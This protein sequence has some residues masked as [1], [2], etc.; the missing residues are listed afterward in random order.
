MIRPS[1]KQR[2]ALQYL[3]HCPETEQ[4]LYGGAAFGGKSFLGCFWQLSRRCMFPETRGVIGRSELKNLKLTTLQTFWKVWDIH[5]KGIFTDIHLN[6]NEQKSVI[7]FSNGSEIYLKDI[8]YYPSDPDFHSLGSLE[9]TDSFVDEGGESV[10]KAINIIFSRTRHNLIN[11][12]PAM[13]IASNPANNWLKHNF[14]MDS[15]GVPIQLPPYRKYIQ[16][17]ATDN[18]DKDAVTRYIKTLERLPLYDRMRLLEG[19]WSVNENDKPFFHMFNSDNHIGENAVIKSEPLYLSF[20]FNIKPT[21]CVIGQKIAGVGLIVHDCVQVEGGTQRLCEQ[22]QHLNTHRA[23]LI[24]T[25]DFSGNTGSTAAGMLEGGVYN[26]DFNI[27]KQMLFVSDY[28]FINTRKANP[29]HDYSRRVCNF[30]FE[31]INIKINPNCKVLITDLQIAQV[32]DA[33]KL[34][35]DR[36]AFKMDACDAFRYLINAWFTNGFEDIV[37]F[38][39]FQK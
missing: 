1:E 6:Y 23:G 5:F 14:V 31:R 7:Y 25:G 17:K 3:E 13:L 21:T 38:E 27:I 2:K 20:D 24:V 34:R 29:K 12:K 4:V 22:L 30:V 39:E 32:T 10:E 18:P 33:G 28:D 35:K 37:R 9:I 19:D 26:T 11:N 16:A 8:K 15:N 36:E